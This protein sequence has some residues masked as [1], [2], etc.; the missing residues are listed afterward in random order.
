MDVLSLVADMLHMLWNL[1]SLCLVCFLSLLAFHSLLLWIQLPL[2]T[3]T[4]GAFSFLFTS[5]Q[6]MDSFKH[7]PFS[8][9][10]SSFFLSTLSQS[11]IP[12]KYHSSESEFSAR[13]LQKMVAQDNSSIQFLM[14]PYVFLN[15]S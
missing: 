4:F 2:A 13:Y 12:L 7:S 10:V 11:W 3:L 9:F 5:L 1:H 15:V 14:R 6:T 8:C